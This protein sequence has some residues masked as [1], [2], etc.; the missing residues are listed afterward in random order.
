MNKIFR[1]GHKMKNENPYFN[2]NQT[3]LSFLTPDFCRCLNE[4]YLICLGVCTHLG[5]V[6]IAHAGDWKGYYCPCHGSHY[7]TW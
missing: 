3:T 1:Y 2:F 7:D 6:P 4:K 5:C